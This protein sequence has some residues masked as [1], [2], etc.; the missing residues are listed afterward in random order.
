MK[1]FGF[2]GKFGATAPQAQSLDIETNA[3][4]GFLCC[5]VQNHGV[6]FCATNSVHDLDWETLQEHLKHVCG[7]FEERG[8]RSNGGLRWFTDDGK[9]G[10]ITIVDNKFTILDAEFRKR[11]RGME[12]HGVIRCEGHAKVL[13][14]I[15]DWNSYLSNSF[16]M[17]KSS[18]DVRL[19]KPREGITAD[20]VTWLC[21]TMK[22]YGIKVNGEIEWDGGRVQVAYNEVTELA[23]NPE[24][25][26]K[27][28]R[29][30]LTDEDMERVLERLISMNGDGIDFC[31]VCGNI[32]VAPNK[33]E[34]PLCMGCGEPHVFRMECGN[35]SAPLIR[36]CTKCNEWFCRKYFDAESDNP[37]WKCEKCSK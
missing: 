26:R 23:V 10:K 3:S 1:K 15:Y 20:V 14:I 7:L 18:P 8:L 16:E 31:T 6:S 34:V 11:K 13:D 36:E 12:V 30:E 5:S 29:T 33:E 35:C 2:S 28:Q 25:E 37:T 27:Q 22:N 4:K 17:E 19:L 21:K 9:E 24:P 32:V